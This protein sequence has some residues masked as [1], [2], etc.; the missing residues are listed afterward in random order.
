VFASQ[1]N[2]F[3][4]TPFEVPIPAEKQNPELMRAMFTTI[5]PRYDFVTRAFSFGMDRRWKR[6]L[7]VR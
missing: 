4:Y 7:A 2:D 1:K 6:V 3:C 5:A